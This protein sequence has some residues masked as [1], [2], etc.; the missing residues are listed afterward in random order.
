M[1]ALLAEFE[2]A[3]DLDSRRSPRRKLKLVTEARN[4]NSA[5]RATMEDLSRSGM[6]LHSA[7]EISEGDTID[8]ELP[9]VGTVTARIKWTRGSFAGCEFTQELPQAAV[10]AS[11]LLS[12]HFRL[13]DE[14]T[15]AFPGRSPKRDLTGLAVGTLV[16]LLLAV[17]MLLLGLLLG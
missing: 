15:L 13:Q 14:A 8:V 16:A 4:S 7:I 2:I 11:L 9:V 6:L 12:P 1:V 5:L 3:A 10:S 17:S